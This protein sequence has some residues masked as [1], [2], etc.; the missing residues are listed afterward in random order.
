MRVNEINYDGAAP[1]DGYGPGFFRIGKKVFEGPVAAMPEGAQF[2]GGYDDVALFIAAKDVL[3]VVLIGTGSEI[4]VPPKAFREALEEVGIATEFMPTPSAC[5]TFN[6]LLSEGR[7][8]GA[9]LIPV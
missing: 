2:W 5:R 8:V 6:V 3:D 7:R 9:A 1:I 4:A